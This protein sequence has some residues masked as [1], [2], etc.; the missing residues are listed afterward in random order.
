MKVNTVLFDLDGT[1]INT[2]DIIIE[3]FKEVFKKYVPSLEFDLELFKGFIGPSLEQTFSSYGFDSKT[4][5]EMINYYRDFYKKNEFDYFEIYPNV[6][7]VLRILKDKGY[8]LGIVTTKFKEAA[9]PSFLHY[10]LDEYFDCF[11]A[12][13]DVSNPKPDPEPVLLA[14]SKVPAKGAIMIGDN[15]GDILAGKNASVYSCGVG[16]SFK[17]RKY[18]E[19]VEPDFMIDDMYG[20]LDIL[21]KLNG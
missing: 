3:T 9:M 2:N 11:V 18:L 10:G 15:Q 7:E 1:L 12:L 19:E 21:E 8:Y 4:V 14:M 13:D 16:W 20:L 5:V 6:R 17:G